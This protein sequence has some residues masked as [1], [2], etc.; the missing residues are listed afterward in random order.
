[1][2]FED[3]IA[4]G[5]FATTIIANLFVTFIAI[6]GYR[7]TGAKDRGLFLLA[8]AAALGLVCAFLSFILSYTHQTPETRYFT[9]V[10]ATLLGAFDMALWAF[11]SFLIIRNY[12]KP[13]TE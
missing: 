3:L 12:T 5:S 8:I 2:Q 9:W 1:M 6:E 4:R 11:A 13:K 7:R 10:I